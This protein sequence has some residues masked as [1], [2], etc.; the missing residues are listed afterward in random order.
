[1]SNPRRDPWVGTRLME[2]ST[3]FGSEKIVLVEAVQSQESA[4]LKFWK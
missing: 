2:K 4:V 1:M 3:M